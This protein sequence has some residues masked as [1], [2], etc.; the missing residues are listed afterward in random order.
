MEVEGEAWEDK[1]SGVRERVREREK[2]RES[3]RERDR[4]SNNVCV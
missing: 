1:E 3:E 4:A 2:A